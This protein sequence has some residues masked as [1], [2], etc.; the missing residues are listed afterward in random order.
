[1]EY[2][3]VRAILRYSYWRPNIERIILLRRDGKIY[4][5]P[6][7]CFNFIFCA[8][9]VLTNHFHWIDADQTK[10]ISHT[11]TF[12][13][14]IL[15]I[16]WFFI[17]LAQDASAVRSPNKWS[18]CTC[19]RSVVAPMWAHLLDEEHRTLCLTSDKD[20]FHVNNIS[21]QSISGTSTSRNSRIDVNDECNSHEKLYSLPIRANLWMSTT[22]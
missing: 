1:M 10:K 17:F 7:I 20:P 21:G 15:D 22:C 13:N 19:S 4:V 9:L 18:T 8:R 11:H 5:F 14:N 3:R 16:S 2:V 12:A 6:S